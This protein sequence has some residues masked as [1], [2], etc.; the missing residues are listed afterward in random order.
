MIKKNL[1]TIVKS[2]KLTDAETD[3]MLRKMLYE[4]LCLAPEPSPE[5][6]TKPK[7][8]A[9]KSKFKLIEPSSSDEDSS[10]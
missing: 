9:K 3:Q 2:Q 5:K 1:K 10:D 7:K 8:K 6:P 4:K